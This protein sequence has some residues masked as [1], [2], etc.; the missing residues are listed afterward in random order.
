[1]APKPTTGRFVGLYASLSEAEKAKRRRSA[2]QWR[3]KNR[4]HFRR[5]EKERGFV[6][7]YGITWRDFEA[8]LTAQGN[9]CAIC[10][11]PHDPNAPARRGKLGLHV[12]HDH[13]TGRVRGLLCNGCNRA[14][15]FVQDRP[16]V[17]RAAA[18][19]LADYAE[20]ASMVA[21]RQGL[22]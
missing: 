6:R 2:R 12:D 20:C 3:E 14:L 10:R 19:Y 8:M 4:D 17:L 9:A 13:K 5:K 16:E 15:G 7:R 22:P 18:D 21:E 11:V 1:M